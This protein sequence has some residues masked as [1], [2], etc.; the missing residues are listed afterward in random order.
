MAKITKITKKFLF[1]LFALFA[2]LTPILVAQLNILAQSQLDKIERAGTL[3][4]DN[5]IEEAE[6]QLNEALKTR[7]NEPAALNLLGTIRAMQGKLNDAEAL[8]ARAIR[9]EPRM[10]GARMNLARLYLLSSMP[11]KAVEKL[12][13]TL[14]L[15]PGNVEANYRL[16][17][18]LLSLGR[19][20]ECISI[21]ETARQSLRPSAPLLAVLGDAYLKKG[22]LDKAEASYGAALDA[23]GGNADALLGLAMVALARSDN[24]AATIHLNNVRN[25]IVDSP[26]LLYK[27]AGIAID[28]QLT[29]GALQALKRAIELRPAEPSYYF[30][31]GVARLEKPDLDEAENAFRQVLNLRPDHAEGQLYLGYIL[32]KQKRLTEA[33]E[34]LEMS[35]QKQAGAPEPF[36][37]LGFYYLGLIAQ[38]QN[39]NEKAENL[40]GKAIRLA[41]S[42]AHAHIALGSTYLRMKNYPAARQALETGVKLAPGDSKAHYNLALLY[43]RLNDPE[44]AQEEM[45]IVERLNKK[46][47]QAL[48]IDQ[49]IPPTPRPR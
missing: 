14:R 11:E 5:Q 48:E 30:L 2:F 13:E 36:H 28:L 32:L 3:I 21:A 25:L 6:R 15:E 35:L 12:K 23:D 45:R 40:F 39:E 27:F 29:E 41:P 44:R 34:R 42:F 38:D 46:N 7:P 31:S 17:W 4:R 19:I 9:I 49:I 1:F 16:A 8:F 18:V 26:E 24:K 20:D 10:V 33:R 43:S 22:A 37:H 47:G